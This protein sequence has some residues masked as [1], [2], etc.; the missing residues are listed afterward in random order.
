MMRPMVSVVLLTFNGERYLPELM[1]SLTS[2][3]ASFLYDVIVI[4]SGS[5]DKTLE[6]V[7]GYDVRLHEIPN[8]EFNHGA[9]RNL[10]VSM[11]QGEFVAFITQSATPLDDRWLQH[12]VDAFAIDQKVAAVYGKHVPRPGC[13][14][15]TER[16]IVEFMKMMGPD[17]KPRVQYIAPGPE[18]QAEYETNEGIVGF[19]SD[20]NSCLRKSVWEK[21]PYQPLNYAEDQAFGRDILRA[22]Y[23]KVYEP[24]AEVYHSHSYAPWRYFRRQ[25]DEY[26]GMREAIGYRQEGSIFRVVGGAAKAGWIDTAYIRS[27]PYTRPAKA[28]WIAYAFSVDFLRRFAGYLAAREERLPKGVVR[29]IS[30]E[31]ES[32]A[33]AKRRA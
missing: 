32:R 9:T 20:V 10:G 21:V 14:P 2:Q 12:L 30:L 17:D 11:A 23:W 1:K 24:R 31:E 6:I 4:D 16:D 7:R 29:R 25:F 18:G 33:K 27:R 26:R 15:I 8:S 3:Q 22:G 13:D 19:Y 5:T 28:K